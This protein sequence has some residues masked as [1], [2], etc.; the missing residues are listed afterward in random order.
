LKQEGEKLQR[1]LIML[2]SQISSHLQQS[3]P[4]DDVQKKEYQKIF[5]DLEAQ[6]DLK[7]IMLNSNRS[8]SKR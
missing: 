4:E 6:I 1:D 3:L 2:E 5:N 7:R 8:T